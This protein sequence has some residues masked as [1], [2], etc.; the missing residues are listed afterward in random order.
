MWSPVEYLPEQDDRH[1]DKVYTTQHYDVCSQ[2]VCELLPLGHAFV[3]LPERYQ[4][5]QLAMKTCLR[6]HWLKGAQGDLKRTSSRLN[7]RPVERK[8]ESPRKGMLY[9]RGRRAW[10]GKQEH[11]VSTAALAPY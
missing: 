5:R 10:R 2:G 4:I 9:R 11:Q 6:C 3:V 7:L 8:T 1:E